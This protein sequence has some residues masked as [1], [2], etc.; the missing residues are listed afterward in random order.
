MPQACGELVRR[1][2]PRDLW[3]EVD[4][5]YLTFVS[6]THCEGTECCQLH[7]PRPRRAHDYSL[8]SL[9]TCRHAQGKLARRFCLAPIE[10]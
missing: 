10:A 5:G 2:G 7:A 8:T 3:R 9:V 6:S 1:V 4:P